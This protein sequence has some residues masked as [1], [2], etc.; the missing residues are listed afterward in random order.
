MQLVALGWW[1]S[2]EQ[3]Q[4][5]FSRRQQKSPRA[6]VDI[7]GFFCIDSTCWRTWFDPYIASDWV[8]TH[9][10]TADTSR[11]AWKGSDLVETRQLIYTSNRS[12]EWQH[13]FSAQAF[14]SWWANHGWPAGKG[15][16]YSGLQDVLM[17]LVHES[18]T[19]D[20]NF[21]ASTGNMYRAEEGRTANLTCS[22]WVTN[23]LGNPSWDWVGF[24]LM[25]DYSL[26]WPVD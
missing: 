22:W 25:V 12:L 6:S 7:S 19:A 18:C 20:E 13:M 24:T 3:P 4:W 9:Q 26:R 15:F 11:N 8:V 17:V 16:G 10:P 23:L 21:P 2:W 5:C 14:Q 1:S